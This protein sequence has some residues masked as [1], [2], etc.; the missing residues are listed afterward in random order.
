MDVLVQL[1]YVPKV[2]LE[3][4]EAILVLTHHLLL[5]SHQGLQLS[6]ARSVGLDPPLELCVVGLGLLFVLLLS[7]PVLLLQA[8]EGF[9]KLLVLGLDLLECGSIRSHSGTIINCIEYKQ[10]NC[11]IVLFEECHTSYVFPY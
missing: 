10:N 1:H 3:F 9:T 4:E 6:D 8:T 11:F 2:R 7:A 5:R